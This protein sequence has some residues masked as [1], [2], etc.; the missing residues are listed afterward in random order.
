MR[1]KPFDLIRKKLL[2]QTTTDDLLEVLR[3]GKAATNNYLRR[4]HNLALGLGWLAWPILAPKMWPKV[5]PKPKRAITAE[6]HA[7]II[8][9]ETNPERRLYYGVLWE[10]GAAQ[11]DAAELTAAQIDWGERTLTYRRKKLD[12]NQEPAA[13]RIG[14]RLEALL[15]QLPSE[16]PL[17]PKISQTKDTDRSAEFSRRCRLLGIA[18]V[19]L[20]SF[21]FSFA[22]RAKTAGLEERF[23]M[24]ALGHNSRA[25]HASYGKRAKVVCPSLEAYEQKVIQLNTT[26]SQSAC[27]AG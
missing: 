5:K 24:A 22:E 16:G 7:R 2:V 27:V 14:P 10:I 23:A 6:E 11:T 17:F 1:S 21:R 12:G 25:I 9:A 20:H 19:S 4:L 26:E 3:A 18:G 13:L 15:R 8:A